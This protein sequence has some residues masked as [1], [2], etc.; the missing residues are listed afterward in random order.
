M[1]AEDL[2]NT[3]FITIKQ[4]KP[5]SK[6][7]PKL[8]GYGDVIFIEDNGKYSGVISHK[9]ILLSGMDPKTVKI[10]RIKTNAPILNKD[11]SI[12]ECARLMI[13][14]DL[15][16]L[17]VLG[18]DKILGVVDDMNLLKSLP[19]DI[20]NDNIKNY[21]SSNVITASSEDAVSSIIGKF[22]KE[23]ISRVPIMKNNRLEGILTMHD[24]VYSIKPRQ[25]ADFGTYMAEKDKHLNYSARELMR[26]PVITAY[27]DD[28]V[29]KVVDQMIENDIN[30]IV[31][32][33][34]LETYEELAGIVTRKDLLRPIALGAVGKVP[35]VI[36]VKSKIE[37]LDRKLIADMVTDYTEK[38][39]HLLKRSMFNVQ[40]DEHTEKQVN[41]K[42]LHARLNVQTPAGRF[43]ATAEN[44]G[45]NN[46]VRDVLKKIDKQIEKKLDMEGLTKEKKFRMGGKTN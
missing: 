33:K 41:K 29:E 39:K 12:A 7:L 30:S 26:R 16:K 28:N 9:Q 35:P 17:P 8:K 23:N 18:N 11:T 43:Y 38:N 24:V 3:D 46:T 20:S 19:K 5:V 22:R 6:A 14:S 36:N 44:F 32:L 4:D 10:K 1:T 25:R 21:M 31:I 45:L 37:D 2:M 42:K 27:E 15:M 34:K 40:I 13:E